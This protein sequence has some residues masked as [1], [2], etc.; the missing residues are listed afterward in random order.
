MKLDLITNYFLSKFNHNKF[1]IKKILIFKEKIKIEKFNKKYVLLKI[2]QSIII[3]L[4]VLKNRK[5][6]VL[7]KENLNFFSI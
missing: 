7:W 2:I 1:F 6:V 5:F 4:I 3:K